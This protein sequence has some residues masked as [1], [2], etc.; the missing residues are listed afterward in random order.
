LAARALVFV[1]TKRSGFKQCIHVKKIWNFH[2]QIKINKSE[3]QPNKFLHEIISQHPGASMTRAGEELSTWS[4]RRRG[5]LGWEEGGS[6][7]ESLDCLPSI[8]NN[9]WLVFG[10]RLSMYYYRLAIPN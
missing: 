4:S 1:P 9:Q 2:L 3:S 5:D 10:C 7:W 8:N 6:G